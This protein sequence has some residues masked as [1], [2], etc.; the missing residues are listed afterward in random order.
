MG[1]EGGG[2]WCR[3]CGV[4]FQAHAVISLSN[5]IINSGTINSA[6]KKKCNGSANKIGDLL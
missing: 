1:E 6:K 4:G 5:V 3:R 2:G